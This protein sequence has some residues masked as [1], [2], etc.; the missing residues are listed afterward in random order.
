MRFHLAIKA[1]LIA[2][3]LPVL[4]LVTTAQA[5]PKPAPERLVNDLAGVL[6]HKEVLALEE[7]LELLARNTSN[8]IVVVTL[9]SLDG[10]DKSE[11]AYSIGESWGV[12]DSK[13]NNGV[14]I[15]V[16]PKKDNTKGE[17]FIA[18]GYGLEGALPDALCKRVIE[19]EMI[20]SFRGNNYYAGID[21]ALSV[22]IPI[23]AGEYSY[24]Q[25]LEESE[26]GVAGAI[27]V[28]ILVFIF[29]IVALARKGGGTTNLGG[30]RRKDPNLLYLILLNSLLSGSRGRSG[31][32]GGGYSGGW[33][34]R[35]GGFG[36]FGGGSFGGGGA[37]GS[38]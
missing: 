23:A 37:G 18:T 6:K 24:K 12:G 11:M 1:L 19:S 30:G 14:V 7:R 25:Y 2:A 22:I 34:G 3:F 33:G 38:W 9:S 20:P 31:S 15:L 28:L 36:G 29:V 4:S 16:V 13:F 10:Y 8:R 21:K 26:G 17:V 5:P 27:A 32:F 35:S